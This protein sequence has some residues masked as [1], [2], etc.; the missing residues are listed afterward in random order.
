MVTSVNFSAGDANYLFNSS[1]GSPGHAAGM[2]SYYMMEASPSG[3]PY[4][5]R[6]RLTER[7]AKQL[8]ALS[9]SMLGVPRPSD[10][11]D[12]ASSVDGVQRLDEK[13]LLL[14]QATAD[15]LA[16]IRQSN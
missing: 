15:A 13:G 14:S 2:L 11:R 4:E 1:V 6:S 7:I 16:K 9:L 12:P 8:V 3:Q 5:S 10:P